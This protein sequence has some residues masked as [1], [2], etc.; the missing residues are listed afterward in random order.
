MSAY[1]IVDC[2]LTDPVLYEQ[3]K[4]L[5]KPL[6]EQHGGKY[7]SRGGAISLKE[8]DLWSPKRIVLLEFESTEQAERFY[9]SP[10]YQEALKISKQSA[11][12][13]GFI[14]QGA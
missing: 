3:Y 8:D 9:H 11:R 7:L 1:L 14:L 2:D 6:V 5:A 4:L 12:R 13:T 10:Q